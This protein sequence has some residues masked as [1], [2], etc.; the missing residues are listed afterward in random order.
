[1]SE[2]KAVVTVVMPIR[3]NCAWLTAALTSV[4]N[5]SFESWRF[6]GYLDGPNSDAARIIS[7]FGDKFS[8]IESET[9]V[10]A[11]E[12]R[13]RVIRQA[14]TEFIACL[15]YDDI[16]P[17]NHL[18]NLLGLFE[19]AERLVLAGGSASWIDLNGRP[20]GKT[21]R[22]PARFLKFQL[23]FR[24]CFAHSSVVFRRNAAIQAGL[25]DSEMTRAY[26]HD[27]WL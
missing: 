4:K 21:W 27:L 17:V 10:G 25:Y 12:A 5:Q 16:W 7:G 9:N 13:N 2:E 20:T 18:D 23:L 24:N 26:D 22:A 1:M 19:S 11:A 3:G 14:S 6:V 15:D 8:T